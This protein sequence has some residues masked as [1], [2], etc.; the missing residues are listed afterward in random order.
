MT[1]EKLLLTPEEGRDTSKRAENRW[2]TDGRKEIYEFNTLWEYIVDEVKKAQL[3]KARPILY[4]EGYDKGFD[5]GCV[6]NVYEAKKQERE[7]IQALYENMGC[8]PEEDNCW[9]RF[10]QALKGEQ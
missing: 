6:F 5:D 1:D 4:Q 3:D 7:R 9:Y 8:V 10:W 2:R